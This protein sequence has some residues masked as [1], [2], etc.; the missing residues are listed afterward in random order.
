MRALEPL[1]P[2][3]PRVQSS[4]FLSEMLE[5]MRCQYRDAMYPDPLRDF[6]HMSVPLMVFSPAHDES[7]QPEHCKA[8][9]SDSPFVVKAWGQLSEHFELETLEAG[10]MDCLQMKV[11]S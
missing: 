10:H 5:L 2:L 8:F 11:L 3:E 6:G 7:C 9:A 4:K 1:E